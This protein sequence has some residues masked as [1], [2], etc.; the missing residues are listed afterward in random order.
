MLL[1]PGVRLNWIIR[2]TLVELIVITSTCLHQLHLYV[3]YTYSSDLRIL[4]RYPSPPV[5]MAEK[6]KI[7]TPNRSKCVRKSAYGFGEREPASWSESQLH[8]ARASFM[9]RE[10][11]S[12]SESQLH[13]ARASFMGEIQLHG[14]R[15]R[16]MEREPASWSES[17]PHGAR[18]SLMGREPASWSE[19]QLH[20][21]RASLMEREPASWSESQLH[22]ATEAVVRIILS[23]G[24][25]IDKITCC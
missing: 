12:W 17:Q 4:H 8:G 25:C 6:L 19:S 1:W 7:Y 18:A 11:A 20:G 22:G 13:G 23:A 3:V 21:A 10:P 15:A 16:F 9:E 24:W 2:F 14:A 5:V